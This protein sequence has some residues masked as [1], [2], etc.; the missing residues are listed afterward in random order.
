MKSSVTVLNITAPARAQLSGT[1]S[2]VFLL[3][4]HASGERPKRGRGQKWGLVSSEWL[5]RS[6]HPFI[7]RSTEWRSDG[8]REREDFFIL[9][10]L[11]EPGIRT[12]QS[13]ARQRVY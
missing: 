1:S 11:P 7:L 2:P 8:R 12:P 9:D 13:T 5:G 6:E 3:A 10:Q 4:R